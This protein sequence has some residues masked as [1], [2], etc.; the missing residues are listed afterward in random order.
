[1][2]LLS[3]IHIAIADALSGSPEIAPVFD[4]GNVPA[5]PP[6]KFIVIAEFRATRADDKGG[7]GDG[8]G[9]DFSQ[10]IEVWTRG[11]RGK[12]D[13]EEIMD[14]IYDR[15]HD[16]PLSLAGSPSPGAMATL[17]CEEQSI[18]LDPD[19]LT[20]RGDMRFEGHAHT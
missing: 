14:A 18:D 1:M 12:K 4:I 2:G 8:H 16:N 15:L 10:T 3:P 17:A 7:D 11:D 20:I 19:G 9:V 5:E 6:A 13:A